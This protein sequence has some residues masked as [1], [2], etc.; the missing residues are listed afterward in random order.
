MKGSDFFA[1]CFYVS[2]ALGCS[3]WGWSW[4]LGRELF[5]GPLVFWWHAVAFGVLTL[6]ALWVERRA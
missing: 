2:V 3:W 1:A 4:V 6:V 5:P